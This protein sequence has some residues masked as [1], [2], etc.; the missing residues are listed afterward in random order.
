MNTDFI[1]ML[2]TLGFD[3]YTSITNLLL[4]VMVCVIK[5]ISAGLMRADGI[6]FR[7]MQLQPSD[8][9]RKYIVGTS[10]GIVPKAEEIQKQVWDY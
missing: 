5:T 10:R 6:A 7:F 2:I 4:I 3:A 8:T 1:S 9:Q